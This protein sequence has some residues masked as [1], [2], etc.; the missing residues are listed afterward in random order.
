MFEVDEFSPVFSS[1]ANEVEN[2]LA[3]KVIGDRCTCGIEE[4][5]QDVA[6]FDHVRNFNA[7]SVI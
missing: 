1:A 2:A 7:S 4:G 6:K 5:W 3:V